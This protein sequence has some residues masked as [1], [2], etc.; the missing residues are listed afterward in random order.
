MN[1]QRRGVI[2]ILVGIFILYLAIYYWNSLS[3]FAGKFI[4]A[5]APIFAGVAIAYVLNILMSFFERHYFPKHYDKPIVIKTR[6][7][8]CITATYI[9]F[10]AIIFLVFKMIIPELIQCV[11]RLIADI[12]SLLDSTV[13]K[14]LKNEALR[15]NLSADTL[16][17]LTKMDMNDW[18]SLITRYAVPVMDNVGSAA[19]AI[20]DVLKSLV[21]SVVTLFISL[22]FSAYFLISRERIK[23]NSIRLLHCY[24]PKYER[25][26][27]YV[28]SVFHSSFRGFIVGQITESV[29]LGVLCSL[30]M[31]I[32]G[33]PYPQ[34]IG[35]FVGFTSL[36]PVAGA[37]IGAIAGA[38]IILTVS[39]MKALLFIVFIIVLQ[40][41]EGNFIY[42]KVVGNSIGLP[43]IWVLVAITVGGALFGI[44]GMLL[45]VPVFAALYRLLKENVM[46]REFEE[47]ALK[48][49]RKTVEE[50]DDN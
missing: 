10:F 11:E 41:I 47:E 39:P 31:V 19:G 9:S 4:G 1:I 27:L 16:D 25:K 37:Y 45:G 20:M 32:F 7:F 29:I 44:V 34:M 33:F 48:P 2:R 24:A 18:E 17:T 38:I 35:V 6:P 21:S 14:L 43:G 42:P 49:P 5:L 30:G 40:Q 46:K 36:I 12:P 22:V 28:A 26:T 50:K 15:D 13:H 3:S 23:N 8:M